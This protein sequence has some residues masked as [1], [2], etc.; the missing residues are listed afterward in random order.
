[1]FRE[2]VSH[3]SAMLYGLSEIAELLVAEESSNS[4]HIMI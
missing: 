1:M 4:T 2:S 3:A